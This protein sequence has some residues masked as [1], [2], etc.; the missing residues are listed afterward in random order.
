MWRTPDEPH[1]HLFSGADV[2]HSV[3][4]KKIDAVYVTRFQKERYRQGSGIPAHRRQIPE[5]LEIPARQRHAPRCRASTNSTPPSTATAARCISSKRLWRADPHGSDPL[6]LSLR[7]DRSLQKCSKM[8]SRRLRSRLHPPADLRHPL[9]Q[10]ELHFAR[11]D[12]SAHVANKLHIIRNGT[13][14]CFYCEK[15]HRALS[16]ATAADVARPRHTSLLS[17]PSPVSRICGCRARD[18]I[19]AVITPNKPRRNAQAPERRTALN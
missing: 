19:A 7:T 1:Q 12:G 8:A 6:L 13:T 5:G 10:Q 4:R 14:R 15:R 17:R 9:R 2:D 3:M 11:A 18:A 16:S